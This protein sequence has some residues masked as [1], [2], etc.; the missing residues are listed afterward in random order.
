M[1]GPMSIWRNRFDTVER[2]LNINIDWPTA[3]QFRPHYGA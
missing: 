2:Q 3:Q 1:A